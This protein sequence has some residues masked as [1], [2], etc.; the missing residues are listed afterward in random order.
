MRITAFFSRFALI[1]NIAF[2]LCLL[3]QRVDTVI[4][5]NDIN[6]GIVVLGWIVAPI[7]NIIVCLLY[8]VRM[9][10]KKP[11]GVRIWLAITNFLFLV[12][13]VFIQIIL[14]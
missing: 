5:S 2:I 1:C 13:Q 11:V 6:N 3:F 10:L 9:L 7:A 8:L 4:E 14:V 12:A